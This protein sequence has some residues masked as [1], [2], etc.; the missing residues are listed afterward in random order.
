[1]Q[2]EDIR[3][4]ESFKK[5]SKSITDFF[6]NNLLDKADIS[7]S[8]LKI[9]ETILKKGKEN[10]KVNVTEIANELKISKSAVSQSITKLEKKGYIKRK[11]NLFDKK[12][13]YFILTEEAICKYEIKQK[14]YDQ[15]INKVSKKMGEKDS[16][17]LSRLLMKLSNIINELRK[18]EINA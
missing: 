11:I 5:L 16:E 15:A 4:V 6:E 8:E 12:I 17:E 2:N 9:L 3:M 7:C 18:E 10:E 14:E 13:N 1:M